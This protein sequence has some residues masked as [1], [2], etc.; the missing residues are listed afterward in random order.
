LGSAGL[1]RIQ[2]VVGSYSQ[3]LPPAPNAHGAGVT[4]L[5]IDFTTGTARTRCQDSSM[6]NPAYL[7]IDQRATWCMP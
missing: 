6:P 5:D 2:V 7:C 1:S 4:V 3:P